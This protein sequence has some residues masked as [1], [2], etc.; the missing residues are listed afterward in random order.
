[1]IFDR[2]ELLIFLGL[3][4]NDPLPHHRPYTISYTIL[5]RC[6]PEKWEGSVFYFFNIFRLPIWSV[7]NSFVTLRRIKLA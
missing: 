2:A 5:R 1:M 3:R 4:W 7:G 6:I